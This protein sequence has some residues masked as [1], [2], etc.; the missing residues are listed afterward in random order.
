MLQMSWPEMVSQ[1]SIGTERQLPAVLTTAVEVGIRVTNTHGECH[2]QTEFLRR[3]QHTIPRSE[4]KWNKCK[5]LAPC[6]EARLVD[7][8]RRQGNAHLHQDH[9]CRPPL[10]RT[11]KP[12]RNGI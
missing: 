4:K 5:C 6:C 11:G 7:K 3:L 9:K 12:E 8:S 1:A 2:M 10:T